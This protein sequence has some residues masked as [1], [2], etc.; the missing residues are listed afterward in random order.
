MIFQ[1]I[2]L[3]LFFV[4]VGVV[5]YIAFRLDKGKIN[6]DSTGLADKLDF[7]SRTEPGFESDDSSHIE[8]SLRNFDFRLSIDESKNIITV[9][10]VDP[11]V[12]SED[13]TFAFYLNVDGKRYNSTPF[14]KATEAEFQY[15]EKTDSLTVIGIVA[16]NNRE[17]RRKRKTITTSYFDD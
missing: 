15:P 14:Q 11:K 10:V 1:S 5:A 4:Y 12:Y 16:N 13:C 9:V 7:P 3:I 8:N 6:D 17:K 2:L